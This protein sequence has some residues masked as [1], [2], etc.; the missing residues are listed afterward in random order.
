M[1][2]GNDTHKYIV[3]MSYC[4]IF[5]HGEESNCYGKVPN[6]SEDVFKKAADLPTIDGTT[7]CMSNT[8]FLA[9]GDQ[10]NQ[11]ITCVE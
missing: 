9:V 8:S 7:K 2:A 6:K 5:K 3:S 1:K 10:H 4:G 11:R